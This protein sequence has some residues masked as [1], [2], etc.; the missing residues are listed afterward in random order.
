MLIEKPKNKDVCI[1]EAKT[2]WDFLRYIVQDKARFFD[3]KIK[4]CMNA[5][6]AAKQLGIH[7]RTAQRW[8]NQYNVCPDSIFESC[9]KVG[10]KSI[11]AEEH[12]MTIINFIDANPSAII[13]EVTKNLLKQFHDLKF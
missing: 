11:L 13:V 12:K 10:R 4:K 9:K 2:K 1:K 6:A 3:L 8:V 5:S 7:I